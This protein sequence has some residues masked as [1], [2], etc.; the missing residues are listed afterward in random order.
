[1]SDIKVGDKVRVLTKY[2]NYNSYPER[3][4]KVFNVVD[5]TTNKVY[6]NAPKGQY[7]DYFVSEVELV[8]SSIKNI[9]STN[10]EILAK[11]II[12][13]TIKENTFQLSYEE[14][15]ILHS[16]LEKAGV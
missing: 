13:V 10:L 15:C 11:R 3:I 8:E 4:G 7:G 5:R 2:S 6:I 1:M 14:A 9:E 16:V 12:E